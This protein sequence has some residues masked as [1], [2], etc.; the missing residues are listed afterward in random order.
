MPPNSPM[1]EEEMRDHCKDLLIAIAEDLDEEQTSHEQS[2]KSHGHGRAHRMRESARLH[3]DGRVGHGFTPGQMLAEFRALRASVLRLYELPGEADLVGVWR[4]NESLDEALTESMT[5]TVL[6]PTSIAINSLESSVMI[7]E[8][9]WERSR[10][11]PP[12]WPMP[13][14]TTSG[15]R[16]SQRGF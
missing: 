15:S 1:T 8:R 2:E 16:E 12:C 4:F 6:R 5:V 14:Q 13:Q 7:C 3:A 10:P 11:A 9:P